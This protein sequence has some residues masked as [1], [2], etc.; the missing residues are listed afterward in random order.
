MH[1]ILKLRSMIQDDP[2]L[3]WR[4]R[5]DARRHRGARARRARPTARRVNVFRRGTP[6]VPD[7]TGLEL[8]AQELRESRRRTASSTPCTSAA[9]RRCIVEPAAVR[10][11]LAVP[12]RQGLHASWPACTASTT[13]PRSRASAST[14]SCSTWRT[15]DRIT[16]KLRVPTD[17]AQRRVGH[18]RLADGRPPGARGLR[19]VRRGLRR[20]P[21]PA[22]DPHARGLRGLP[23]APRLPDRRRAGALHLQRGHGRGV[24][25]SEPPVSEY[26]QQEERI[27][28]T[29]PRQARRA[30]S[31]SSRSC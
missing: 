9:R 12:A 17:A 15:L 31:G 25:R 13:T 10:A 5:Y 7:A 27:D 29:A 24:H 4:E 6:R 14:T 23:A 16:V 30:T 28:V 21:R 2:S 20:P 8:L 18:A 22:P 26:R 19:H 1:G 11:T 3:G